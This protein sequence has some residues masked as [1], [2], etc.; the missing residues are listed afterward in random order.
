VA[1]S[2]QIVLGV[3]LDTSGLVAG[4]AKAVDALGDLETA[5]KADE[6]ALGQMQKAMKQLQGS[7]VV[8]IDQYRKLQKAIDD[9]KQSIAESRS[10]Y[11]ELGGT[12]TKTGKVVKTMEDKFRD[13]LK[14]T[15]QMG[16]PLGALSNGLTKLF[17]IVAGNPVRA[18]TIALAA[19]IGILIAKTIGATKS[20]YDYATAQAEVRRNELLRLE[21]LTK[22][23]NYYGLAADKAEDLQASIDKVAASSALGRDQV[24]GL[25]QSLYQAGLRGSNLEAALGAAAIKTSTQGEAQAQ[26]WIGY[27]EAINRTGG[28]VKKFAQNV[29]NQL[30][31]LAQRQMLAS[32]VQAKKLQESYAALTGS[33][34]IAP[35]LKV[36][37]EFNALFSQATA[38]GRF[39]KMVLAGIV[40]PLINAMT[41]AWPL[42]KKFFQGMILAGQDLIIAGLDIAIW[43]KETFGE[44]L[45]DSMD[46]SEEALKAGKGAVYLLAGA[47]VVLIAKV[48]A[49]ALEITGTFIVAVGEMVV[50]LL[51]SAVPAVGSFVASFVKDAIPAIKNASA[52]MKSMT[53]G[54][55]AGLISAFIKDGVKAVAAFGAELITLGKQG[56]A[57]AV[58]GIAGLATSLWAALPAVWAQVTAMG[59]LA[60]EV[61]AV[62]WPFLLAGAAIWGLYEIVTQLYALWKEIDWSDLGK[63]I[64]AGITSFADGAVDWFKGLGKSIAG[65]FASA[66]GAHSPSTVFAGYGED[67]GDGL[68]KGIDASTPEVNQSINQMVEPGQ[69][70]GAA[71]QKAGTAAG[72]AAGGSGVI[73]NIGA[74]NVNSQG[75]SAEEQAE[76]FVAEIVKALRTANYQLGAANG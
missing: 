55:L 5:I 35:L 53:V 62:T 57:S 27:A 76:D 48:G 68:Q 22:I 43:A 69:Q 16:G 7:T 65:A 52:A 61:L 23:P 28:D 71:A 30:G 50:S 75:E 25:A 24:A 49:A 60:V 18:A 42:I 59:A 6:A 44:V 56:I 46:L 39:L 70:P 63:A 4:S 14:T 72:A 19:G 36:K 13:L 41:K 11:L 20:L 9:R 2:D 15:N 3:A 51:T 66:I 32:E 74:V 26:M 73:I 67:I 58:K 31:G 37:A 21:G 33:I 47:F 45:P 8:D 1:S 10:K 54:E 64:W 40:Q 34:K 29:H 38:S 12:F 17:S